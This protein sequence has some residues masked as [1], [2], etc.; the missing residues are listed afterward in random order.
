[1]VITLTRG[2]GDVTV[3]HLS[4]LQ[5]SKAT[6]T[7]EQPTTTGTQRLYNRYEITRKLITVVYTVLN[8]ILRN[9][10]RQVYTVLNHTEIK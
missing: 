8:V 10:I 3:S 4:A 2:S 6:T 9:L 5:C 1:M 7:T